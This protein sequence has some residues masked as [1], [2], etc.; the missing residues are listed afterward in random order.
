LCLISRTESSILVLWMNNSK[1]GGLRAGCLIRKRRLKTSSPSMV[2]NASRPS[3]TFQS[4]LDIP[5]THTLPLP[6]AGLWIPESDRSTG[7]SSLRVSCHWRLA[8]RPCRTCSFE[9]AIAERRTKGRAQHSALGR[10]LPLPTMSLSL[11][12]GRGGRTRQGSIPHTT[13]ATNTHQ[14]PDKA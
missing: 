6:E 13:F 9:K 1:F 8:G 4:F 5:P 14:L 7:V 2:N 10:K 11:V 3:I 12:N